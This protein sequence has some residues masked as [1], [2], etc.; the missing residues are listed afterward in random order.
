MSVAPPRASAITGV[1]EA[2]ASTIEIPKSSSP[3]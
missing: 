2:S 3:A 1:P